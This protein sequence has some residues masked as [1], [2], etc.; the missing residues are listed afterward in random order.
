MV[1]GVETGKAGCGQHFAHRFGYVC[2]VQQGSNCA[3]TRVS[4][5]LGVYW[6]GCL[7]EHRTAE[8]KGY[9][10]EAMEKMDVAALQDNIR[11]AQ[12]RGV[13][14]ETLNAAAERVERIHL[15]LAA[16]DEL[17]SAIDGLDLDR[18]QAALETAEELEVDAFLDEETLEAAVERF[19]W[20]QQRQAAEV[21]LRAA[22][23]AYDIN[24]LSA[25]LTSA[26]SFH[27]SPEALQ[28][29]DD[30]VMVLQ[31]LMTDAASELTASVATRNATRVAIAWKDAERLMAVDSSVLQQAQ[32][33]HQHLLRM[34]AAT[35]QLWQAID[36]EDLELVEVT[37]ASATDLDAAPDVLASGR[38][39]VADLA[40][41]RDARL[42]LE[43]ALV[44]RDSHRLEEAL[45]EALRLGAAS[46]GLENRADVRLDFLHQIDDA[47][48]EL[49]ALLNTDDESSLRHAL[50]RARE[51]GVD[52]AI[53]AQG[54]EA[55]HRVSRLRHDVRKHM[56]DL[57][58]TGNNVDEL[59][60]AVDEARRLH[61]ASSRRIEAAE[62]RIVELR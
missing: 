58:E 42:V 60:A 5:R 13:D 2:Y 56:V 37:L 52:E 29:G 57:T 54:D 11:I 23:E 28:L 47:A 22:L 7:E 61:A 25:K 45:A 40:E 36:G 4:N 26:R 33:R 39:R 59:Q 12:E 50:T 43:A 8:A 41:I 53:L 17:L 1:D 19:A 35:K 46:S 16:R 30:R 20:L 6:R 18:L 62:R 32:R 51:I 34:A 21:A 48:N 31:R 44:G 9:L 27:V 10:Q 14:Q 55:R 15:M 38:Q 24:D 3:G 49:I